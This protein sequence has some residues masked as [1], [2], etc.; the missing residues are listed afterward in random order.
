[1]TETPSKSRESFEQPRLP[2]QPLKKIS[3]QRGIIYGP[4][5]SRRLGQSLGRAGVELPRP[6]P[7]FGHL[8]EG[9]TSR[10]TLLGCYHPSQQ[11]TF[12]GKLTESMLDAVFARARVLSRRA[13][14]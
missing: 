1:M 4:V 12:T 7:S 13:E 2:S 11:N 6:R 10:A 5:P 3:L 8:V 14:G 9:A